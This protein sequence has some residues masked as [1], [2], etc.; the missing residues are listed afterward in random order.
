MYRVIGFTQYPST[1]NHHGD[2]K[3]DM[4]V[5][6]VRGN[7][8]RHYEHITKSSLYRVGELLSTLKTRVH[9]APYVTITAVVHGR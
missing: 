8:N 3:T 7:K 9:L 6:V 4:A 2:I 5:I 1:V